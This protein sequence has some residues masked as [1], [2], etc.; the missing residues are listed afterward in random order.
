[1]AF[2]LALGVGVSTTGDV[3]TEIHALL[4]GN[5]SRAF[6]ES[7]HMC[8][9]ARPWGG[10]GGPAGLGRAAAGTGRAL[11]AADAGGRAA[12]LGGR[13]GGGDL[14]P[15]GGLPCVRIDV[16]QGPR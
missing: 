4:Q 2:R 11:C 12:V 1:M 14:L 13:R 9:Q 10:V 6:L 7:G 16:P 15:S 3:Y 5:H 8:H